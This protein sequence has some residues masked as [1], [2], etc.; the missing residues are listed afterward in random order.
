M[1]RAA[2]L[3]ALTL[4]A[5]VACQPPSPPDPL[6]EARETCARAGARVEERKAACD[7]LLAAQLE[8]AD[9]VAALIHR[10]DVSRGANDPTAALAD[11]NAA[12]AID[13]ENADAKLGRAT[14]LLRSGQLDAAQPLIDSVIEADATSARALLLR[15]QLKVKQGDVGAA[16][17]DFDAAIAQDSQSAEAFAQRGLAKQRF[18]DYAAAERDFDAAIRLDSR[19]PNARS[20]RCW[21]RIYQNGD[22]GA[23]ENDAQSA[24]EAEPSLISA[25]LCLGIALLRQHKYPQAREVYDAAV[26]LEPANAA[27]LFG[28]GYARRADGQREEG[29]ADIRRAY[30][31]NSRID[32]EFE[33]LGVDF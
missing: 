1:I 20:G 16:M 31:F 29:A 14:V 22:D 24:V 6:A 15:A 18:E 32:E 25:R 23:A 8:P 2:I 3:A 5:L 17:P 12:L 21:N 9:R 7:A 13:A 4:F 19:E 28:R 11:Y 33:R 27:A 26:Q 30:E 10:G